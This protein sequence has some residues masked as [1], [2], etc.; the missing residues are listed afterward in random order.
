MRP[1]GFP[2]EIVFTVVTDPDQAQP[3]ATVESGDADFTS[4][5]DGATEEFLA[6]LETQYVGRL[7]KGS[8]TTGFVDMNSSI[9][10]FDSLE[11]RKAVNLAI[12][13]ARMAELQG[14]GAAITCQ[15]LP[16][17]FPGYQPYCPYTLRPESGGRWTG[18]DMQV[19]KALIDVSGTR[20]SDVTLG[21]SIFPPDDRFYYLAQVLKDLGYKVTLDE[22]D[23]T[24]FPP[25]TPWWNVESTQIM[26]NGWFPDW[27]NPGNFL[28]IFKCAAPKD[29][30]LSNHCDPAFDREFDHALQLQHTDPAAAFA[31]WAALDRQAVD[32]A[33][34]APLYNA[35]A[36]F[37]SERVGNYQY[38]S[39]YGVLFDQMWVQ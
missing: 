20:G 3:T 35:G 5:F 19:A 32:L 37:V 2:D 36:G 14:P 7:H 1:D 9:P 18:P 27:V 11:A 25:D 39:G 16:P 29:S 10:P 13:R 22:R 17:G 6:R 31:E 34:L 24:K 38:N 4:S 30:Y 21:P 26:I 33:L 15:L 12:D 8:Y 23:T 28:S